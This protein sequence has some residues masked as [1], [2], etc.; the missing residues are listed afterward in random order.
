MSIQFKPEFHKYSS[1][2]PTENIEWLSVTS[3]VARYKAPF[4]TH[5][6]AASCSKVS[7]ALV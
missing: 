7:L 4:D 1:V 3:F 6:I 5:A 2:D